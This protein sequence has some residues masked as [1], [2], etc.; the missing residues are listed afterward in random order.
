MRNARLKALGRLALLGTAVVAAGISSFAT[1]NWHTGKPMPIPR[2][3][4]AV[5]QI[6]GIIY[7]AGG[8]DSN[9]NDS[10]ILQAYDP[11]TDTWK[12][13]ADMPAVRYQGDGAG[14]INSKLYVAGGWTIAGRLPTNT[15]FMYDPATDQWTSRAPLSHL[16]ACGATAAIDG[17]LYVTTPCNG[18]GGYR[19]FLDRYDPLTDTWT[20]MAHSISEHGNGAFGVINGKLY[21]AGGINNN[22]QITNFLEVYDPAKNQWTALAPMPLPV[23]FAAS[24]AV[25]GLFYVFGGNNGTNDLNLVQVY[26]PHRNSWSVPNNVNGLMP[27]KRNSAGAAVV[28]GIPFVEGGFTNNNNTALGTNEYLIVTPH[29][30]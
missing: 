15:L 16:S 26:D 28:Y 20:S 6:N 4:T 27:T 29:I 5:Q 2:A 11:T 22:F 9:W 8:L 12:Q 10:S 7:V 30:P 25:N 14:V 1:Q 13:L 19:N 3:Q 23:Y 18:Y 17:K 24:A 21:V